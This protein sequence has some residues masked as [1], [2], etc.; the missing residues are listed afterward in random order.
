MFCVSTKSVVKLALTLHLHRIDTYERERE[1]VDKI[2]YNMFCIN[3][4]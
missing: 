1:Y 3:T 4:L 2:K